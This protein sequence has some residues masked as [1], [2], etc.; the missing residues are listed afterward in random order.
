MRGIV[1]PF[2]PVLSNSRPFH[3]LGHE[4]PV[5]P[6][7]RS[8]RVTRV[9]RSYSA[10]RRAPRVAVN[11]PE[12]HQVERLGELAYRG[13]TASRFSHGRNALDERSLEGVREMRGGRCR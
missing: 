7:L 10:R 11:L 13:L 1:P 9:A 4:L 12:I 8:Y 6:D 5:E 2:L 3:R